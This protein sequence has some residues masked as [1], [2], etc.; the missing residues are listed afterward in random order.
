MKTRLPL[1]GD[2]SMR[3]SKRTEGPSGEKRL[4]YSSVE[5]GGMYRSRSEMVMLDGGTT[6]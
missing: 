2:N 6:G 1:L 3:R 4:V 5:G